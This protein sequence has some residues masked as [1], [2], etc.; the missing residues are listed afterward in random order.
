MY[1]YQDILAH[2]LHGDMVR[3]SNSSLSSRDLKKSFFPSS[4][5]TTIELLNRCALF[6]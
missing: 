1:C 3:T 6:I 2:Q 5:R 4:D